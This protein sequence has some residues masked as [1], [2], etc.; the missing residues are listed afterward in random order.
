VTVVA[1]ADHGGP[2]PDHYELLGVARDASR[3]E[4]ARA[5][6]RRAR[7]EHP[8]RRPGQAGGEAPRPGSPPPL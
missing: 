4:I 3:E 8:D 2:G 6:R 7:A 1:A 5:R